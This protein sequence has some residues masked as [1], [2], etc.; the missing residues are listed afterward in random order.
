LAGV[1]FGWDGYSQSGVVVD[2]VA[3]FTAN[4]ESPTL[5]CLRLLIEDKASD[6]HPAGGRRS[7]LSTR[8]ASI[9]DD[10]LRSGRL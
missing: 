2:G 10:D 1:H 9:L 7:G 4:D 8:P 6:P 3:H 5:G